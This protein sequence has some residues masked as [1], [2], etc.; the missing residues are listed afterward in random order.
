MG[1]SKLGFGVE[2]PTEGIHKDED[3]DEELD[4]PALQERKQ[5]KRDLLKQLDQI[6][7]DVALLENWTNRAKGGHD[8]QQVGQDDVSNLM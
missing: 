6:K 2:V 8:G 4:D 5:L 3:E 7:A 1:P